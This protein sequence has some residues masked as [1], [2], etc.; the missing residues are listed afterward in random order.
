VFAALGDPIRLGILVALADV[1]RGRQGALRQP[2]PSSARRRCCPT[3]SPS[4]ARPGSRGR[5][6]RGHGRAFS[7]IRRE[8]LERRFPGLLDS[9]IETARRDPSVPRIKIDV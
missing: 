9:V 7:A 2:S 1:R 8:E 3:T 5:R 4:C 6:V